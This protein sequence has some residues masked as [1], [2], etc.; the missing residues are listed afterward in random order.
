M[1]KE[2]I[3]DLTVAWDEYSPAVP[4]CWPFGQTNGYRT[5]GQQWKALVISLLLACEL[6]L[7]RVVIDMDEKP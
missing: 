5:T 4:Y 6:V 2:F 3:S 1:S 7:S